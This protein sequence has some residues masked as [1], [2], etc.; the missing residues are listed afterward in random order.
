[1]AN[2]FLKSPLNYTG[3]K[4]KLLKQI[5]PLF[6]ENIR[7]FVDLFTGGANVAVN[8]NAERIIANDISE[9][10]IDIFR[11]I[12]EKPIE[13]VLEHVEGRISEYGLTKENKDGYLQFR[14]DY[15]SSDLKDPLDL[16]V[17]ICYSFNN[18]IRFNK[19]G[20]YNMPFGKDRSSFNGSIRKNLIS[21][22]EAFHNKNIVFTTK[23]FAELKAD[24]L[25]YEDFVYC[26]PPYLITCASYNE[27]DGWTE[28][29]ERGLLSMLD[30]LNEKGVKFALSNVLSNKGRVNQI[31]VDWS[32]KYNVHHLSNT[33]SNCSY[34]AKDRST[35]TT[36]E[37]LI[38]NY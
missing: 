22:S 14:S 19:Y 9:E 16:F 15:N 24:K 26:D 6:P 10:V 28:K 1:M 18:Q 12:Q 35:D 8:V 33:Y 20:E 29:N 11:T 34:H 25:S 17:L 13:E 2:E 3:G 7:T 36:D 21:F 23:D 27:Q 37:V 30:S 32:E 4:H 31:L 5:V 38:T